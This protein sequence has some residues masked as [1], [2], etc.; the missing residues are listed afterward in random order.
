MAS[1]SATQNQEF[2]SFAA[3]QFLNDKLETI[4]KYNLLAVGSS[5]LLSMHQ[6]ICCSRCWQMFQKQLVETGKFFHHSSLNQIY[7]KT[8]FRTLNLLIHQFF[9]FVF[10]PTCAGP[11]CWPAVPHRYQLAPSEPSTL[12]SQHPRP[13]ETIN[14]TSVQYK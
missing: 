4:F 10:S 12:L 8:F 7:F 2:G 1:K 13:A 11:P 5:R 6:G 14:N 9:L 3:K